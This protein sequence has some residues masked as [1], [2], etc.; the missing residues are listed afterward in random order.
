MEGVYYEASATTPYHFIATSTIDGP[1]NASNAVGG[2]TYGNSSEFSSR[3]VP[4]LEL[5]GVR[6]LAVHSKEA[7]AS[8]TADAR[9]R[10]VAT[11]PDLDAKAPSGWDIFEV[12]DAPVVAPLQYQPIVV[13]HLSAADENACRKRVLRTGIQAD[14]L[15]I[16]DWQDCIGVPWF[17]DVGNLDRPL[18]SSGPSSWPHLGSQ[19]ALGSTKQTLPAVTVSRIR[20]TD[21][22]VSFHV[23]RTGVPVYVKTSWFPNWQV[24]GATG[25]Y[26]ATPNFM[27]VVP[28]S[29]DVTL[30][31]AT[32]TTEWVGRA[33]TGVGI[34][35]VVALVAVPMWRRR[36]PRRST[37]L[38]A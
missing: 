23:S 16:H 14:A 6:Y 2:I 36:R 35:G 26:R 19:D 3:G 33:A 5:M 37:V 28:T 24:D 12:R 10:L 15:Q 30:R 29:K 32:T 7:K 34:L 13:D 20:S 25:P 27:V 4:Y 38:H 22:T 18:V 31:Y 21:D 8:A 11:V 17:T 9:L 1:G